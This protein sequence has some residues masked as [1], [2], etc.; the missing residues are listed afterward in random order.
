M[1]A[2]LDAASFRVDVIAAPTPVLVD[3]YAEWCGPCQAQNPMLERLA[4]TVGNRARLV[5]V[6]VDRSPELADLFQVR[7]I[8]TM[9]LFADGKIANRFTGIA[10]GQ[11]L[12]KAIVAVLKD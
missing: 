7:S 10:P 3:F 4:E 2:E 9:I 11:S 6:I 8:P 1:I 5:K 12:A